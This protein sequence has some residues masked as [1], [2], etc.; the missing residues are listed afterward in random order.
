MLDAQF[1]LCIIF[2]NVS[3]ILSPP[4]KTNIEILETNVWKKKTK[5]KTENENL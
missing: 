5:K 2:W 3:Q 1:L 4:Y